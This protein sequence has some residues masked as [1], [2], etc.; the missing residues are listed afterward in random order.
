MSARSD[1]SIGGR[2]PFIG[3][4]VMLLLIAAL[5][6]AAY[7]WQRSAAVD[8]PAPEQQPE[9]AAVAVRPDVPLP[10]TLFL[11]AGDALVRTAATVTRQP[12][13]QLEARGAVEAL[14]AAAPGAPVLRDVRLRALYVDSAGT[15]YVDLTGGPDGELRSGVRDE[16]LAVYAFVN[17][18]MQ[19][20]PDVKQVRLLFDGREAP[21]LA[22][23]LDLS[24]P[25]VARPDL[26]RTP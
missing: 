5:G 16:L 24:Q 21:T 13:L 6:A 17:T 18:L 9:P 22:G 23:H 10:V 15:A 7:W 8:G 19:N 12:E 26:A 3:I 14:L 4:A 2:R 20:F 11:P 1:R 25:F